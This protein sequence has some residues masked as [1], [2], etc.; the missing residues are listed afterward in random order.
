MRGVYT[1]VR[2]ELLADTFH[3]LPVI[4]EAFLLRLAQGG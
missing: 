3:A 4:F 1:F 2:V